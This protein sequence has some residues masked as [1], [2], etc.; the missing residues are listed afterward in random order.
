[1]E[2]YTSPHRLTREDP[3]LEIAAPRIGDVLRFVA[4]SVASRRLKVQGTA[5][6]WRPWGDTY[7]QD[8]TG[9]IRVESY[10]T[11]RVDL[12]DAVEVVGFRT[13]G[14]CTPM[15]KNAVF[16]I[17]R[18]GRM[19]ALKRPSASAVLSVTNNNELVQIDARLLDTGAALE[20]GINF[21]SKPYMPSALIQTLRSCLER[22]HQG[23]PL[24][25]VPFSLF[26]LV[27]DSV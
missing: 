13:L 24:S 9:G 8:E 4:P 3:W 1:M 6:L 14:E 17:V 10:E 15:L 21:L 23:L 5:T 25:R 16:R 26:W 18:H 22:G 7:L 12:G 11:N 27:R 19:P 20:E 2:F